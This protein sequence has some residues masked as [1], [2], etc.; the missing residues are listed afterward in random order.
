MPSTALDTLDS[1]R[2]RALARGF[3]EGLERV[4]APDQVTATHAH[5]FDVE[6]VVVQGELWL[7]H[8]GRTRHLTLGDAFVVD[9]DAPH[10]E[11]YGTAGAVIWAARRTPR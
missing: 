2:T 1:F 10:S 9:H 11:R 6:A 5:P 3:D 4:W 8:E 7:T